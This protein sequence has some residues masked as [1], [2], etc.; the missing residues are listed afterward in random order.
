MAYIPAGSLMFTMASKGPLGFLAV[1]GT[2]LDNPTPDPTMGLNTSGNGSGGGIVQVDGGTIIASGAPGLTEPPFGPRTE[3]YTP[4]LVLSNVFTDPRSSPAPGADNGI[5]SNYVD[6]AYVCNITGSA[7]RI[8]RELDMSGTQVRSWSLPTR[9]TFGYPPF[10]ISPDSTRAY[11]YDFASGTFLLSLY[12]HNLSSN[13]D[14]G[15]FYAIAVAGLN[16][17]GPNPII[18]LRDGTIIAS[19]SDFFASGYIHH[20]SSGGSLLQTYNLGTYDP[21]VV[22]PGLDDTSF[23]VSTYLKSDQ[24]QFRFFEIQ[25]S[26]GTILHQFDKTVAAAGTD[27]WG[28]SFCVV[29]QAIGT[30]PPPYVDLPDPGNPCVVSQPIYWVAVRPSG[31]DDVLQGSTVSL[32]DPAARYGGFKAPRVSSIGTIVRAA[33]DFLTGSLPA[34][35]AS[36]VWADHDHYFRNIFATVRSDWNHS[37]LWVYLWDNAERLANLVPRLMFYG[38]IRG[39]KPSADLT[40]TTPTFDLIGSTYNPLGNEVMLP[41]QT[42]SNADFPGIPQASVNLGR[43]II[44]GHHT[45]SDGN[46]AIRLIDLGDFV[47]QDS[48]TR[49]CLGIA[50]HA[51]VSYSLFQ[52]GAAIPGGSYGVTA[53][54]YGQT[55]WSDIVPSTTHYVEINNSWYT[56]AFVRGARAAAYDPESAAVF[57]GTVASGA[58]KTVFDIGSGEGAQFTAND[59]IAVRRVANSSQ[60][61]NKI[62][63]SVVG[64]TITLVE[65]VGDTPVAGDTIRSV[66]ITGVNQDQFVYADVDGMDD[67]G[68]GTGTL[69]DDLLLQD[70]QVLEQFGINNYRKGLWALIV[71]SFEFYPGNSPS[72]VLD[73]QSW[74]DASA[75]SV[76]YLAGGFKGAFVIGADGKQRSLRSVLADF[77][78]SGYFQRGMRNNNQLFVKMLDIDRTRF[79]ADAPPISDR[80]NI[81]GSPRFEATPQPD[82]LCN[83]LGYQYAANYRNDSR[84][85]WNGHNNQGNAGSVVNNGVATRNETYPMVADT[86]T[87]DTVAALRLAFL[88]QVPQIWTWSE[89]LCGLKHDILSGVAVNHYNGTG[90]GGFVNH[91]LLVYKQTVDT[92]ED[93]VTFE[94]I[95][96]ERLLTGT[97]TPWMHTLTI[98]G[99]SGGGTYLTGQVVSIRANDPSVDYFFHQWTGGTVANSSAQ[100]TTITMPAFDVHLVADFEPV[101]GTAVAHSSGAGSVSVVGH[102]AAATA[103]ISTAGGSSYVAMLGSGAAN[104]FAHGSSSASIVGKAIRNSIISSIASSVTSMHAATGVGGAL[105]IVPFAFGYGM[106]TRGAYGLAGVNPTLLYVDNLNDSGAGSMRAAVEAS[107]PRIVIFRISG[108]IVLDSDINITHPYITIAGQTAPSPGIT[109]RG[110][111]AASVSA[112]GL[113]THTHD[114]L[115]QH[116]RI[117]PGDG[118]PVL[119]STSGH[120]ATN[121]YDQGYFTA[122]GGG[123]YNI[124][125]DHCSISWGAAKLTTVYAIQNNAHVTFWKCIFSEALFRAK[126]VTDDWAAGDRV[127]SLAMALGDA[128]GIDYNITIYGCLFAHNCGRN[129]ELGSGINAQIIN[130]VFYDWGKDPN[131]GQSWGTFIYVPNGTQIWQADIIGNVYIAG[132]GTGPFSTYYAVGVYSGYDGSAYYLNDNV[133]DSTANP[134]VLLDDH[135]S[136]A[137]G[138]NFR[139]FSP[140]LPQVGYTILSGASTKAAVLASAGARPSD[141]DAVDT[142]VAGEVTSYDG[143][144]GAS[145]AFIIGGAVTPIKGRLTSQDDAGGWPTLAVNTNTFTVPSN[146]HSNSGDGYTNLEK[147]LQAAAT[148]VGG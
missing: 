43:P 118:G 141:R 59:T 34:Q 2:V 91:G 76:T 82:W 67:V 122:I 144:V 61:E 72:Y 124:V 127:T 69:L 142:R 81:L 23:W 99:G 110:A 4:G 62:I 64:D 71:A 94:A 70:L 7:A 85:D 136:Y 1:D 39:D 96:V 47:C 92:K 139:V 130:N 74:T 12:V 97:P 138:N 95:D 18:A 46:G 137:G 65:G 10:C 90:I 103:A 35:S 20:L 146:P 129:P 111:D 55:G 26:D 73:R 63:A 42:F 45:N 106:E 133:I 101:T 114:I 15:I 134:V 80:I 3:F 32:R 40:Y 126:N 27:T 115:V 37:E 21:Y 83:D 120:E 36:V 25:V 16:V 135:A 107:G 102:A 84:G 30:P 66:F 143:V 113:L 24:T 121:I 125:F 77:S 89:S 50:G 58:S 112:G 11:Y 86:A 22:T 8:I 68:D 148:A 44:G 19:I 53:W 51:C 14:L 104:V 116:I 105:P 75:V 79:Y 78:V 109:I 108:T 87:A 57:L 28:S 41:K 29:R 131:F 38:R 5:N 140:V 17:V 98:D 6:L 13:S 147:T 54:A 9:A 33:S 132:P 100:L 128:G 123:T 119:F 48:K 31:G 117:R 88:A 145:S 52:N 56:L 49:R 60:S 93:R